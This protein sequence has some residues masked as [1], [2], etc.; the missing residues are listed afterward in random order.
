VRQWNTFLGSAGDDVAISLA[1]D[2]IGNVFVTGASGGS[3]GA[4]IN[5]YAG[6]NDAFV[7]KM[8]P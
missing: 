2:G 6:G 4:P 3:W 8:Q 5:P 7:A 1:R